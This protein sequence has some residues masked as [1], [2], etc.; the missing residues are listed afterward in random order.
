[1]QKNALRRRRKE[2]RDGARDVRVIALGVS[3]ACALPAAPS[4]A[5]PVVLSHMCAR[6]WLGDGKERRSATRLAVWW[7]RRTQDGARNSTSGAARAG[8]EDPLSN[9]RAR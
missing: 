7:L 1:M 2:R 3:R 5:L 4:S 9:G 6:T 8:S